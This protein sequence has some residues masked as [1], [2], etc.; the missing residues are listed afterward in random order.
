MVVATDKARIRH[1]FCTL[2]STGRTGI[3]PEFVSK[4]HPLVNPLLETQS[5]DDVGTGQAPL[6]PSLPDPPVKRD[7]S[8]TKAVPKHVG[9]VLLLEDDESFR[10]IITDCLTEKG[11]TVVAVQNGADGVREVLAGDFT[12]V[13]SD[14]VMPALSGDI[15][16]GAVEKIRPDLCQR[17]V[18]MTGH[19]NEARTTAFVEKTKVFM[20]RKP[21][22]MEAL[23]EA[24]VAAEVTCMF[25]GTSSGPARE[26][27][28]SPGSSCGGDSPA[29]G[30]PGTRDS[31]LE[32]K[33]DAILG[34]ARNV[35]RES[36]QPVAFTD[37]EP[38]TV[39]GGRSWRFALAAL[40]VPLAVVG[41]LW[42]AYL[43]A[44]DRLAAASV[45]RVALESEWAAVAPE[46]KTALAS[47][48]ANTLAGN[49]LDQLS[50]RRA[51]ARWTPVLRNIVPEGNEKIEILGIN[52][53]CEAKDPGACEVR[54]HGIAGGAASGYT[55]E[56]FRQSVE[57][58][59]EK[60]AN[61][62]PVSVRFER[63]SKDAPTALAG[64]RRTD[65]ILV[66]SIG[67][68]SPA[69]AAVKEGR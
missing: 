8:A 60:N 1:D 42:C 55:A 47:R 30:M 25:Q 10:E 38:A 41:G 68:A 5:G 18:F 6:A 46:L 29:V 33:V 64:E 12:V 2:L 19:H 62:R 27:V 16:Y 15:F 37:S 53:R 28:Q 45:T 32:G 49:K 59:L 56:N 22:R 44:A 14:F 35:P 69:L 34:R 48:A 4:F 36:R 21:F 13:I 17:F 54:V 20:L 39:E 51:M 43:K 11:Y 7:C 57:E 63:I 61:G 3:A 58:N 67:T 23:L 50:A 26:A 65:F 24:V 40:V 9:R 66:A 52:A 31:A